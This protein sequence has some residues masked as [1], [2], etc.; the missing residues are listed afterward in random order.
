[1]RL[2]AFFVFPSGRARGQECPRHTS[3][4]T[5]A[6]VFQP[7]QRFMRGRVGVGQRDRCAEFIGWI[8]LAV[9][10]PRDRAGRRSRAAVGRRVVPADLGSLLEGRR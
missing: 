9:G 5:Q 3:R 6:L 4:A 2:R 7:A 8:L 1:M 10:A